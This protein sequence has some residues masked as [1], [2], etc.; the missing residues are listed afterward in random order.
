[1]ACHPRSVRRASATRSG[2]RSSACS[3]ERSWRCARS[4][5]QLP[6]SRPAVSRHLRLLKEA[7]LVEEEPRGTRRIYHLQ[8]GGRARR[9]GLPRA[10]LGRGGRPF[11]LAA[12]NMTPSEGPA[13]THAPEPLRLSFEVDC[14]PE[15]AFDVWTQRF[16]LWWPAD[17][18]VSGDPAPRRAR[19]PAR[20]PDLRTRPRRRPSTS[21]ARSPSGSR[22]SGSAT[23]G[24]CAA[25]APTPPRWRSPS[26]PTARGPSS[27]SSTAA[28]SA[29][30]PTPI[31]GAS[32]TRGGWSDPAP[33]LRHGR[34]RDASNRAER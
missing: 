21:G 1:M 4:P 20:R 8:R 28:G 13:V 26:G 19:A 32:A 17:H 29:S 31:S 30:V 22:P 34:R 2:A 27:R 33:P 11:R 14:A 10:G 7:G 24:T 25:T 6:I 12:E 15:D 9:P 18:T 3:G 16:A 23:C 5:T